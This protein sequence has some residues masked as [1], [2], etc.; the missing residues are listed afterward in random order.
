M[1]ST[2]RPMSA[3]QVLDRTFFVYRN[4]FVLFMGIALVLP[5]LRLL[6]AVI[7]VAWLGKTPLVDPGQF[8]PKMMQALFFRVV[9]AV[10]AAVLAGV[11]GNA[12]ASGT[13]AYAV[14]MVH[15]GRATT[16]V[17]CYRRIQPIFWRVLGLTVRILWICI[18][19]FALS[20]ALIIVLGLTMSTLA[21][22]AGGS[23]GYLAL[24]LGGALIGLAGLVGGSVWFFYAYCRYALAVP[25]CMIEN[26][27]VR[28]SLRRSKFLSQG[29]KWRIFGVYFLSVFMAFV[30][31][32]VLE[33]PVLLTHN[34]FT[35][36]GQRSMTS[37]SLIW[38]QMAQ[39]LG[40]AIAGPIAAVAMALVY[41]DERVRKEA[42]DLQLMMQAMPETIQASAPPPPASA[43]G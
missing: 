3:S 2:L 18:W 41:Y 26:L 1:D 30:L 13:T 6:A 29:S 19:P 10:V 36:A 39:F 4:N 16:I 27:S 42:F 28:D 22:S 21:K 31:T 40:T 43:I 5:T 32:S 35:L 23:V 11:V 20:Y 25:A 33:L 12:V 38:L 34:V 17:E 37:A 14:S 9:V 7:Q 15:L 8:D 24:A